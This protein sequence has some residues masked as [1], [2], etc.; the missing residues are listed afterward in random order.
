[1]SAGTYTQYQ[2]LTYVIVDFAGHFVPY[3]VLNTTVKMVEIFT[4][5]NNNW[6]YYSGL[7]TTPMAT[8]RYD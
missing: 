6:N 3:F 8:V 7:T 2:N 1:M 4:Q 5:R